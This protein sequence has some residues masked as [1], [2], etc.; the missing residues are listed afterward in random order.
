MLY[1][2]IGISILFTYLI[3][4]NKNRIAK[5]FEIY[6]N[7]NSDRKLHVEPIPAVGGT[8]L[9]FTLIIIFFLSVI[10]NTN[11]LLIYSTSIFFFTISY[12]IGLFD[13]KQ[14]LSIN[15][16][17]T[18][19]II[20]YF[21][22]FLIDPSLMITK[23]Y[24]NNPSFVIS[25]DNFLISLI[26]SI[27][28]IFLLYNS[29]NFLDGVN[30]NLIFLAIF[31]IVVF[32]IKSN[33]F[34]NLALIIISS[35]FICLIFNLTNKIF[36][37]NSGSLLISSIL[38]YLFLSSHGNEYKVFFSDEI[39]VIFLIPGLDMIRLF[40]LRLKFNKSPFDGDQNH[41]HHLLMKKYNKNKIFLY[42]FIIS[43]IP[44][45]FYKLINI[46]IFLLLFFILIYYL[47]L[48]KSLSGF[49]YHNKIL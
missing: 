5:I 12:I 8:A 22:L 7:P 32:F 15:S 44:Y 42:Y 31:W 39:V 1:L 6:D 29:I 43:V 45:G 19:I 24:V 2:N 30:G 33:L 38:S 37:G 3:I 4:Y 28:C 49:S 14:K 26:I 21:F 18:L 11:N 34:S 40:F 41:L 10:Y 36:M 23:I 13:D 46:N 25:I 27:F 35:L 17:I 9:I 20:N 47:V 48:L 16:R